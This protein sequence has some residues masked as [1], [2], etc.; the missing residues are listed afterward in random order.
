M[1]SFR[2]PRR[3][4][5]RTLSKAAKPLTARERDLGVL[6]S[7]F[8]DLCLY[9][10]V[11]QAL[12]GARVLTEIEPESMAPIDYSA[13][14]TAMVVPFY[15]AQ[16]AG[17]VAARGDLEEAILGRPGQRPLPNVLNG[18]MLK[19]PYE[20]DPGAESAEVKRLMDEARWGMAS[21][22]LSILS[23][24]AVFGGL[25][26]WTRDRIDAAFDATRARM[27]ATPGFEPW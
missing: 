7:A 16:R 15:L 21:A 5:Q 4:I 8:K 13:V 23:K 20:Q 11:G 19:C 12:E 26:G 24:M 6:A 10:R 27:L 17:E 18:S 9:D 14:Q 22:D 1:D 25:D 2:S 3:A